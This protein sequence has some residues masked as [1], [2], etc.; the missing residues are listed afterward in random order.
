MLPGQDVAHLRRHLLRHDA[1]ESR[2]I[3]YARAPLSFA[4][5]AL[6]QNI[7]NYVANLS[8]PRP[9]YKQ[10]LPKF[11]TQFGAD[12]VQIV[13]YD[14][15]RLTCGSVVVDFLTRCGIDPTALPE[16]RANETMNAAATRRA[17]SFNLSGVVSHG[18]ADLLAARMT[19]QC[20]LRRADTGAPFVLPEG[21]ATQAH[22]PE[23]VAWLL[24]ATGSASPSVGGPNADRPGRC[25]PN[26]CT[27]PAIWRCC[28]IW[29]APG[30]WN[31]PP[32]PRLRRSGLRCSPPSWRSVPPTGCPRL[33]QPRPTAAKGR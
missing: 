29:R 7:R 16:K 31:S 19:L 4:A 8:M 11:I 15:A 28:G 26:W 33:L 20:A 23:D 32:M 3:G 22:D 6:R 1:T 12:A 10:R 2:I 21:L 27:G 5:S 17:F 18:Q 13:P 25:P 24:E 9:G 30:G 14:R